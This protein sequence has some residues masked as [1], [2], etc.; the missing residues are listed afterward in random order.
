MSEE[1]VVEI[2][3]ELAY[4]V[5]GEAPNAEVFKRDLTVGKEFPGGPVDGH[6]AIVVEG[7]PDDAVVAGPENDPIHRAWRY[8][9]QSEQ[10]PDQGWWWFCP[11]VEWRQR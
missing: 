10:W 1:R 6:I 5:W 8:F 3:H 9:V 7:I 4:D 11:V 2:T